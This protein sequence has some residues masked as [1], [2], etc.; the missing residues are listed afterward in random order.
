MSIAFASTREL[1]RMLRNKEVSSRELTELYIARI[2][3]LDEKINA[4][5]M[6]DFDEALKD[7]DVADRHIATK[8]PLGPLHGIPM[9]IK[10]SYNVEGLPTTWGI[11]DFRYNIADSDAEVVRRLRS[12]GAHFMGKSNV[13]MNLSDFQSY[14]EIYGTTSNPWDTTRSPGG[15]SGGA[16]AA[17]AAGL[18]ALEVGSDIG[19]SVRNPAH[20]CG[21][22]AHKPTWGIVPMQGHALPGMLVPLDLA[23]GGP[24]ARSAEDLALALDVIA[25][26]EPLNA[27]GWRLNLPRPEYSSLKDFRV[28]VWADDPIAP[29]ARDVADRAQTLANQLAKAGATVSDSARPAIDPQHSH[30]TYIYMLNGALAAGIPDDQLEE[31][32]S[33]AGTL[34]PEDKSDRANMARAAT[35]RH[36]EWLHRNTER[37]H[38]RYAWRDFFQDWDILICPQTAT[39]AFPHDHSPIDSRELTVDGIQQRFFQQLW[40]A[41]LATVS[42]LP[43][44]VF[45]TGLSPARLPIGLQ[46][47][48]AEFNDYL[49]I[50]FA[51]LV[52]REI[53]GFTPP[54][55]F[56]A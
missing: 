23:V 38:L 24:M 52:S 54:P 42:Y 13:P 15:S 56:D 40:W 8:G 46:A 25:G 16:A 11:P 30:A 48:G 34:D 10:E 22:F 21:V 32:A 4:I 47:V 28:A 29:V 31:I 49:C 55:G 26:P 41:G 35:Q 9:T 18:T 1:T 17:L 6:R 14:N 45:P 53:G 36:A 39:P 51:R 7:A 27:H 44:T 3:R 33:H 12:A 20:Y 50:E 19:G 5:P 37:E 2:E 43:S